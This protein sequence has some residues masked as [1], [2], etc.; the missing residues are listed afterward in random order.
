[1]ST[2]RF[3]KNQPGMLVERDGER[4][5]HGLGCWWRRR[6]MVWDAGGGD[7]TWSGMLVEETGHV[8]SSHHVRLRLSFTDFQRLEDEAK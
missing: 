7:G 2:W 8:T 3:R 4:G 6:D 5:R 1:M